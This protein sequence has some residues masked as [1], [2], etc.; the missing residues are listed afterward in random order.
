MMAL[1]TADFARFFSV[2]HGHDPFPWQQELVQQLSMTDQWPDVLDLP[3]GS[4]KTA[5]L[6]AAVFHLALRFDE[7]G[8]S[9]LRIVLVVDRRLVVDDAHARATKIADALVQ[10]TGLVDGL[11]N[12]HDN[13]YPIKDP[14]VSEVA[15]RLQILAGD[16]APPLLAQRLRGGTPLGH[17]WA[18]TPTQ[19]VI[20]CSTVD[21]VGSRLLFRGYGTSDRMKPLHAGLLGNHS[22]ILLDEAH[23]S[24]PFRQTVESIKRM[25]RLHRQSQTTAF[26]QQS[27]LDGISSDPDLDMVVLSATPSIKPKRPLRLSAK[28]LAQPVL[29]KRL[30]ASKPAALEVVSSELPAKAFASAARE[31]VLRLGRQGISAPAVGVVVNRVNLARQTFENLQRETEADVLLMIGR[32]REIGRDRIANALRP[33]RTDAPSRS[34]RNPVDSQSGDSPGLS[35]PRVESDQ[36]QQDRPLLVVATQCLEVGVDL[37]LD[38]LV[39]QVAA[40]D[41][42]R[43]RFGRLNRAGRQV[44]T[45]GKILALSDEIAKNA[46]DPVYGDRLRKTWETLQRIAGDNC[47]DFGISA[48]SR[49]LNATGTDANELGIRCM[50]APTLMPAYLDLWSHTCPRPKASPDVG[51]FLHGI[52]RSAADVSLVWRGDITEADLAVGSPTNLESILKLLPPRSAEKVDIPI[53]SVRAWLYQ[54]ASGQAARI[55]DTP[56]RSDSDGAGELDTTKQNRRAFRWAGQDDPHTGPVE[57]TEIRPGDLIVVPTQ[58]GGCDEFGW[59]PASEAPVQDVADLAARPFR[60]HRHAVRVVPALA[61]DQWNRISAMLA[62]ESVADIELVN[63]L[64]EAL[65]NRTATEQGEG[66]SNM[67]SPSL[68]REPVEALLASKGRKGQRINVHFPY[69]GRSE[70]GAILVAPHG[71]SDDSGASDR[72]VCGR[73]TTEDDTLSST[74]HRAVGIEDHTTHVVGYTS[75]YVQALGLPESISADLEL[76]AFL[77][78]SGK[79]DRRFQDYLLGGNPW[80]RQDGLV[81]AKSGRR[82]PDYAWVGAGLPAGWRHEAASVRMAQVH[83][84]FQEARDSALVLWL[85]GT[86]HG[87]GRPFFDFIDIDEVGDQSDRHL[88][89]LDIQEW[90]IGTSPGPE[91]LAFDFGGSD[92]ASLFETLKAR[93]GIWRLAYWEAILR[94]ADHRASEL[95]EKS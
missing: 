79:A 62:D 40:L 1:Q 46:D 18:R 66:E 25:T 49:L 10:P 76:A 4:G 87:F 91:S 60:A 35:P 47:V 48:L 5:V 34:K 20:L 95:E 58:Y 94:L 69:A 83:P 68:A 11:R 67:S 45:L 14:V 7:P 54:R 72:G 21:Q 73:S 55:S 85:I 33:Y 13:W 12:P 70:L 2:I 3:T 24:E 50:D 53:W 90:R 39:T 56:Q 89:C 81:L 37:D 44:S 61:P 36:L 88:G 77:H 28:D 23:L 65:P 29:K 51:L 15:R 64:L 30:E 57:P 6:D 26:D 42:L 16:D 78:D 19:P 43:Q 93:Y 38:G 71:V 75:R 80:N 82:L 84:K 52:D 86:H 59:A 92:W 17:D 31:M 8:K 41:S 74:S 32:S 63:Q 9:A 27:A 22:L